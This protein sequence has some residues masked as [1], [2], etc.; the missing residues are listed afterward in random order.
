M[1]ITHLMSL[2]LPAIKHSELRRQCTA[3]IET[4]AVQSLTQRNAFDLH[5]V[6]SLLHTR[7]SP[8]GTKSIERVTDTA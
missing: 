3:A 8:L 6:G 7:D 1:Q 2:E 5:S 4:A